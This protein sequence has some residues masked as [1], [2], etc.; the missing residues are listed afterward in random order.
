MKKCIYLIIMILLVGCSF[1]TPEPTVE[2]PTT[3][4]EIY[5]PTINITLTSTPSPTDTPE[6]SITP[7]V[8]TTPTRF[9]TK[10]PFPRIVLLPP[11]SPNCTGPSLI[12]ANGA[13]NGLVPN[14]YDSGMAPEG[15]GDNYQGH[16]DFQRPDGCTDN[17]VYAPA[18]GTLSWM[19]NNKIE[20]TLD[21]GIFL[22]LNPDNSPEYNQAI[23]KYYK[24]IPSVN[25]LIAHITKVHEN[26]PIEAG[27]LIGYLT[28]AAGN[29][30]IAYQVELHGSSGTAW[31]P[32]LFSWT[33][34]P[35]CLM[36]C[37]MKLNNY[38]NK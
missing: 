37:D 16:S 19:N 21:Y 33:I 15:G 34:P 31:S 2:T 14:P 4:I 1:S 35:E 12:R 9:P 6:P 13:F 30:M 32:A 28:F 22:A 23:E 5:T 8:T 10:T 29:P 11:F 17:G 3:Q 27:E 36:H 25:L 7:T 26:G 20:L 24:E 38:Y 18:S